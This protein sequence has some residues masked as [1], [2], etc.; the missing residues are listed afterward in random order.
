MSSNGG[1]TEQSRDQIRR[2]LERHLAQLDSPEA[3]TSVVQRTYASAKG[4]SEAAQAHIASSAPGAGVATIERAARGPS[5]PGRLADVLVETA[6]QG[7]ASTKEA[8]AIAEA[9]YDVLGSGTHHIPPASRRGRAL[10]RQAT[11]HGVGQ[12]A[13]LEARAFGG[14]SGLPHPVWLHA[15]CETVG[16]LATG[17]WIWVLGVLGTYFLRVEGSERAVKLTL[18][19]VA[20][21]GFIAERPAKVF[22]AQ[23]RPFAHLLHMMLL[24]QKPRGRTFPSGHAATSFAAAWELGSVWPSRRPVLLG[25]A[26]LVSM[27]R[28]Y[29][30]AHDPGEIVAGTLLGVGLAELL[31]R[32][33]ERLLAQVD[34]PDPPGGFNDPHTQPRGP[35]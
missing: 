7:M 14:L 24:G 28:V 26:A 22:A 31:R 20:I 35:A 4:A 33:T 27:S 11:V 12:P 1:R 29:L 18:P 16:T 34:L 21:V 13:W 2:I 19:T 9:A 15:A 25:A 32:P 3:A 30:G 8:H 23:R 10:L 6:T 5:T 17:G